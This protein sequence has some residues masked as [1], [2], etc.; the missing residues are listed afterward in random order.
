MSFWPQGRAT[1]WLMLASFGLPRVLGAAVPEFAEPSAGTVSAYNAF[2]IDLLR[3]SRRTLREPNYFLSPIGVIIDLSMIRNGATG[4]TERQIAATLHVSDIPLA[5]LNA[6]NRLLLDSSRQ[7]GLGTE[8]KIA[9]ALWIDQRLTLDPGF[10]ATIGRD[11]EAQLVRADFREPGSADKINRWVSAHTG[12]KISGI[13]SPPLDPALR[14]ALLNAIYFKGNWASPFD[15]GLTQRR[16][17]TLASGQLVQCPRMMRRA[18]F[19]YCHTDQF[20][21]VDLPYAGE[22]FSLLVLLPRVPLESFL[23]TFTGAALD[24]AVSE[25]R[26]RE[27]I[28]QLPRFQLQGNYDL[29]AVLGRLGMPLAFTDK[30]NFQAISPGALSLGMMR[31]KTY[32]ALDETGTVAAAVTGGGMHASAIVAEP[33]PFQFVVDRPFFVAIRDRHSGLIWFGGAI[34]DP[35]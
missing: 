25:L 15:P 23:N 21:A 8:L 3:Q 14:L 24:S 20:Q 11:Y 2:G 27:G 5:R 30:A 13:V 26:S 4:E 12:G 19:N 17:F 31:Q 34:D 18:R 9:D 28:V 6:F 35:R 10:L 29:I 16:P 1:A 32:L 33:A 7:V 22:R